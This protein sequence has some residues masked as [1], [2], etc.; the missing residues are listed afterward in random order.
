[1]EAGLRSITKCHLGL[2]VNRKLTAGIS[3]MHFAPTE[4]AVSNLKNEGIK[5][6][7]IILTGNTVI[8]IIRC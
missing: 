6:N 5:S 7:K 4:K 8:D 2:K 3:D 1:M